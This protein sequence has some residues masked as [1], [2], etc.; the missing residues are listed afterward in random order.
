MSVNKA[1][2]RLTGAVTQA[3][4][5]VFENEFGGVLSIHWNGTLGLTPIEAADRLAPALVVQMEH[6]GI[7]FS[8]VAE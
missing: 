4:R 7:A 1:A 3:L 6:Y 5:D 8:Q 2:E